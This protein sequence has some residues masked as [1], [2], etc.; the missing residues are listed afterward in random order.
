MVSNMFCSS[1]IMEAHREMANHRTDGRGT[2][3]RHVFLKF[4]YGEARVVRVF[5][6]EEKRAGNEYRDVVTR[7]PSKVC[8]I[9]LVGYGLSV[10]KVLLRQRTGRTEVS[11]MSTSCIVWYTGI[12]S[13]SPGLSLTGFLPNDSLQPSC[14]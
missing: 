8:D 1:D 2:N 3:I 12:I 5:H 6:F 10:S 9:H 7:E 14:P 13:L 11:R 4:A